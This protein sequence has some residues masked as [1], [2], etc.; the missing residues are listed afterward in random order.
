LNHSAED[1]SLAI[2]E[3]SSHCTVSLI[4]KRDIKL[5]LEIH[6]RYGYKYFD[7]LMLALAISSNC[8]YLFT[9]DLADGQMI[10]GKLKIVNIYSP[11]NIKQYL[12]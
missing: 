7:C 2:D 9:E 5:V 6:K 4:E 3:I 10:N 8:K 11:D 12:T 1:V